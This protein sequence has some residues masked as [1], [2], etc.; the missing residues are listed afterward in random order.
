MGTNQ[1]ASDAGV[2]GGCDFRHLEN[3]QRAGVGPGGHPP[4]LGFGT[5]PGV[6]ILILRTIRAHLSVY[7]SA[8]MYRMDWTDDRLQERFDS[9]DHRFDEV[10]RRFDSVDRR[11]DEVERRVDRGFDKVD[12][13]LKRLDSKIDGLQRTLVYGVISLTSAFVAGLAAMIVLIAT[14]I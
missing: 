13:E 10:G 2:Q 7:D 4:A 6:K 3:L 5:N 9:I 1:Q 8:S 11:I 12:G 14:Q